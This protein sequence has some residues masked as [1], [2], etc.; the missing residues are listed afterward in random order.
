MVQIGTESVCAADR[1]R[2]AAPAPW[3]PELRVPLILALIGAIVA[4]PAAASGKTRLKLWNY[5]PPDVRMPE[6][7]VP[8]EIFLRF[9]EG[10]PELEIVTARSM[11]FRGGGG[12]SGRFMAMASGTAP[13]VIALTTRQLPGYI[14]QGLLAPLNDF[15]KD[16]DPWVEISDEFMDAATVDGKTYAVPVI[17]GMGEIRSSYGYVASSFPQGGTLALVYRKDM[18]ADAGLD[19]NRPPQTW[20]ELYEYA[21][22]LRKRNVLARSGPM[23]GHTHDEV[24]GFGIATGR[25]AGFQ[26]ANF[27]WQNG[28]ELVRSEGNR[29]RCV[30]DEPAGVEALE[31]LQKLRWETFE[32]DGERYEGTAFTGAVDPLVPG[33]EENLFIRFVN[34]EIAMFMDRPDRWKSLAYAQPQYGMSPANVGLALLPAG[35]AGRA[36]AHVQSCWAITTQNSDPGVRQAAWEYIKY[37]N[38]EDTMRHSV[39][40][41]VELDLGWSVSPSYLLRFG[42]RE[43]YENIDEQYRTI[44][45]KTKPW[46]RLE[47]AVSGWQHVSQVELSTALEKALTVSPDVDAAEV[48]HEAADRANK[49]LMGTRTK[50]ERLRSNLL[51]AAVLVI[52]LVL[53]VV[54]FRRVVTTILGRTPQPTGK[55]PGLRHQMVAWLYLLPAILSVLIWGYVPLVRGL[56]MAFFD[57]RLFGESKFILLD[58][59]IDAFGQ[60]LFWEVLGNT[61]QYVVLTLLMGFFIPLILAILLTEVP[62]GKYLYRTLYYLPAVI[63]PVVALIM[64][65]GMIFQPGELGVLNKVL[66]WFGIPPQSWLNDPRQAMVCLIIP[67][68]WGGAG[69]ASLIYIAAL[70]SIPEELYEAAELDHASMWRKIWHITVPYLKPLVIINFVGAFVGAF[71]AAQNIFIMTEGGP[72]NATRTIGLE[73]FYNAFLYLKFGYATAMAWIMGS[74]LMGFTLVNLRV[75]RRVEFTRAT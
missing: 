38:S 63:A 67:G 13:D 62:K 59:F 9:V 48:L 42:F 4:A 71:Q 2:S 7:A 43:E 72:L 34:G 70:K 27:V 57:Y 47:P 68:I 14:E 75:L 8:R 50:R 16:Y 69:P 31:F 55:P 61:V 64:W 35:R 40:A 65:R 51:A 10:H 20:D 53:M 15:L 74:V 45:D 17:H 60:P 52:S 41:S 32:K 37:L 23:R 19:P 1:H 25:E 3:R 24:Y 26:F 33:T 28:G 36:H 18:F 30:F 54:I 12:E 56:T 5:W 46:L 44:G 11:T 73:I 66:D 49:L 29:W 6:A 58:N 39:G 21:K 22:A